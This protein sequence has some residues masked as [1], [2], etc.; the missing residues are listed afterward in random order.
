TRSLA[1]RLAGSLRSHG[2]FA[3]L[4]RIVAGGSSACESFLN[5]P[6]A[7]AITRMVT[8]SCDDIRAMA[9]PLRLS[10]FSPF[11]PVATGIAGRSAELVDVLRARGYTIDTYPEGRAHDFPW[12]RRL[13]PSDLVVYQFGNSS[14]HDYEW[15]Y[16]LQYPG[17]VVLHDTHLHHARAALLLREKRFAEYRAEFRWSEPE[18]S[19]DAAEL[20]IAGL[21]SMLYYDWAFVRSLVER[22]RLVAVHGEGAR[23]ELL[24][25]LGSTPNFSTP[26]SSR[27]QGAEKIVAIRLGEGV[28]VS[29]EREARA[30]GDVRA[31]YGID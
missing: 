25:A 27:N 14:H 20:A 1:R 6:T 16:A 19:P 22:S 13:E 11:P 12:R 7:N 28:L 29:P 2:S 17:L 10:W 31:R 23:L 9:K 26:N 3:T 21:D 5:R 18:V 30:R 8:E 24:D 4:T 15:P